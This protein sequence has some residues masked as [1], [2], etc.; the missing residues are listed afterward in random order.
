M[1]TERDPAWDAV[2][3]TEDSMV[4]LEAV[5][6]NPGIAMEHRVEAA[7]TLMPYHHE[8]LTSDDED[9]DEG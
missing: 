6:G 1:S 3:K 2:P 5:M 8:Q 9:E 7:K 4:F